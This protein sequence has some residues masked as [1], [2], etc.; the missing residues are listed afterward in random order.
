MNPSEDAKTGAQPMVAAPRLSR[1]KDYVT[2]VPL[3]NLAGLYGEMGEYAKA[4]PLAVEALRILREEL[5]DED[6][7]TEKSLNE[8]AALYQ[9]SVN[10]AEPPEP[11]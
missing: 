2:A 1:N 6:P 10:I 5:G 8:L 9:D 4:E 3:D 7:T 11:L